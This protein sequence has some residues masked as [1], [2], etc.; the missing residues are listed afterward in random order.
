MRMHILHVVTTGK[1]PVFCITHTYRGISH[2]TYFCSW[3]KVGFQAWQLLTERSPRG[4]RYVRAVVALLSST[5]L[6]QGKPKWTTTLFLALKQLRSNNLRRQRENQRHQSWWWFHKP[7]SK[8]VE[9]SG[10][11][12][13]EASCK[14]K[15]AFVIRPRVLFQIVCATCIHFVVYMI[16]YTIHINVNE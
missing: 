15:A 6:L 1:R 14:K 7:L 11:H 2:L 12:M 10:P 3:H 16:K 5:Q 4:A 9:D 13:I 8:L